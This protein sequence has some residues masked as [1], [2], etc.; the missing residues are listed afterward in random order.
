MTMSTSAA[1]APSARAVASCVVGQRDELVGAE[2]GE[3]VEPLGVASGAD[4]APGAKPLRDLDGHR[5]GIAGRAEDEHALAGL[6]RDA[7]AQR[8]P[9]RHRRV[10]RG[11]DLGHV[12]VVGQLDR[13]PYV[14]DRLVGHRPE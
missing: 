7:A 6:D 4:H 13:A 1:A 10:H 12:D 8:D 14:D 2:G 9:R 5:P 11:R 3:R